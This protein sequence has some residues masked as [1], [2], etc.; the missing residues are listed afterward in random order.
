MKTM[1]QIKEEG[2]FWRVNLQPSL[3]LFLLFVDFFLVKKFGY[4]GYK[5]S[6]YQLSF[7]AEAFLIIRT[8]EWHYWREWGG[9]IWGKNKGNK[10]IF[11]AVVYILIAV[12]FYWVS[13]SQ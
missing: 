1:A 11:I 8:K 13:W 10:V 5:P 6:L 12:F 3:L 7:L 9:P 4:L 2:S